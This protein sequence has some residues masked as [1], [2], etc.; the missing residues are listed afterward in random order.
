MPENPI[1]DMTDSTFSTCVFS[2][3]A[4]LLISS[5]AS[6]ALMEVT[7]TEQ[8]RQSRCPGSSLTLEAS[9]PTPIYATPWFRYQ[10]SFDGGDSWEDVVSETEEATLLIESVP[11]GV[12]YRVIAAEAPA[13]L[14]DTPFNVTSDPLQIVYF[15]I[16]ECF[17]SP[18]T[19]TGDLCNEQ[20]GEN[21][22]PAGDFGSGPG[23]FAA[24][25]PPGTTTYPFQEA[26]WPN[27]GLYTIFNFWDTDICMGVFPFPCWTLPISDNS[28]DPNGYVMVINATEGETGIFYRSTVDG[29]CENTTYQFSADVKNLNNPEFVPFNPAGTDTVILPNLDFIIG[30]EEASLELLQ[31]APESYNTGN[32][33]NDDRW[34]TFGFSF[35]TQPGVT[36]ISFAIR[37]NA[38]GGGG[39]DFL[40]DN[41]SF[42][43]CAT[44]QLDGPAAVCN[45]SSISLTAR[46]N[47]QIPSP[48]FRWQFSTDAGASWNE[49]ITDNSPMI[50]LDPPGNTPEVL[51]RYLLAG[52]RDE[53]DQP[54]CRVISDTLALRIAE[55]TGATLTE[56]I[57]EGERFT[58][59]NNVFDQ[60]GT[61]TETLLSAGGCDSTVILNLEVLPLA[62]S[63]TEASICEGDLFK[64]VPY[65]GDTLITERFLNDEG[66]D[67]IAVTNLLVFTLESREQTVSICRGESFR[68]TPIFTDTSILEFGETVEGCPLQI[69]YEVRV[70][71]DESLEFT[72]NLT[73]CGQDSNTL[74]LTDTYSEY[75][76]STGATTPEINISAPGTYGVTVTTEQLCVIS[77]ETQVST[78]E[79]FQPEI[80]FVAPDC[81]DPNT[82]SIAILPIAGG[83]PPFLYSLNERPFIPEPTFNNLPPGDYQVNIQ[84]GAGC[85][86]SF[87]G[88]I[89][90]TENNL[91]LAVQAEERIFLGDSTVL[92]AMSPANLESYRW[93][94]ARG[95]S[96]TDCPSPAASPDQTT[97]YTVEVR[98][99]K[100]C[101][102][103]A[104][105]TLMVNPS[106]V[107]VPSVFTPNNDGLNDSFGPIVTGPVRRFVR[108]Q[109]YDRWGETVFQAENTEPE[110]PALQWDGTAS[111]QLLDNGVFVWMA[112]V[113]LE[114]GGT[115]IISG[116]VTL[117]K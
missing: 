23:Q 10:Q 96:C 114:N 32:V 29:L 64:G 5:V 97:T 79:E 26:D 24:A 90:E 11:A 83:N 73:L 36:S 48:F 1:Y 44:A 84:D 63:E 37:N 7:I 85:E 71:D 8:D 49:L 99:A 66:C 70:I 39:N 15:P 2:L 34:N 98:D 107:V 100:G 92:E 108:F 115:R 21:I 95:L 61:Y 43:R 88:T 38:P 35:T 28:D 111:G 59:G 45:G 3:L 76:W 94:P 109:I 4:S 55:P 9:F 101:T 82:G 33:I 30:P 18:V 80:N 58:L 104:S 89:V 91:R 113:E 22:F 40:L 47:G 46:T 117:I 87:S 77:G 25:L 54:A 53:L 68:G 78:A 52:S 102:A 93:T 12:Q 112:E 13:E 81:T 17:D 75:V 31:V 65:F 6:P 42:R 74:G 72:G 103:S 86:F 27:D 20:L 14:G 62:R 57:C 41:I 16:G 106:F 116:D 110:N 105:L 50:S 67:S 19:V 69:F 56:T 51:Y 60:S